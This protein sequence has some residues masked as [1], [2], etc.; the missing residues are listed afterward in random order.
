LTSVNQLSENGL[1]AIDAAARQHAFSRDAV[2][3]IHEALM[4]GD[5]RM[6]QFSHPEFGGAGQWMTGGMTMIG[7]MFNDQLKARIDRLCHELRGL[8]A[9]ARNFVVETPDVRKRRTGWW[10]AELGIPTSSGS[11]N[12]MRYAYFAAAQRLVVDASG[13]VTIYDTRG[14]AINGFSQQQSTAGS[15]TF[16]TGAG[17]IDLHQLAVVSGTKESDVRVTPAG[18]TSNSASNDYVFASI[19]KLA[20][21]RAKGAVSLEEFECKKKELLDRL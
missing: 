1:Q 6:A 18:D 12:E 21:L 5:G 11:Q 17:A 16:E 13:K 9:D 7:D 10:P 14:H 20:D 3:H 15:M 2:L 4:H 19:E 8:Q